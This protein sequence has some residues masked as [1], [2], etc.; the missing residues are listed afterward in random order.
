M[1]HSENGQGRGEYC[2]LARE[3]HAFFMTRIPYSS[4]EVT[5]RQAAR[6]TTPP[7][8]PPRR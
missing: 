4:G 7:P 3:L 6:F 2:H 8:L 1:I 5:L